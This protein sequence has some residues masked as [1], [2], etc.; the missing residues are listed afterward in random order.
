MVQG[1]IDWSLFDKLMQKDPEKKMNR[2]EQRRL[3][4]KTQKAAGKHYVTNAEYAKAV[5]LSVRKVLDMNVPQIRKRMF[6]TLMTSFFYVMMDKEGYGE[7]RLFRL[8][9]EWL[10]VLK[11]MVT[12]DPDGLPYLGFADMAE[13]VRRKFPGLTIDA[14]ENIEADKEM[15]EN[16][17]DKYRIGVKTFHE[18]LAQRG[19]E[20]AAKDVR[21]WWSD[22]WKEDDEA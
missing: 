17:R 5:E 4:K 6:E 19:H 7:K 1:E 2:A 16:F 9:S 11:L 21:D 13:E 20:D 8:K 3:Q 22:A 12:A 15:L 14:D 10:D 18:F